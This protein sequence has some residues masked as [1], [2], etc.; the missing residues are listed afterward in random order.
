MKCKCGF[1]LDKFK[2]NLE[3]IQFVAKKEKTAIV[4]PKCNKPYGGENGK[5]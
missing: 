2:N 1:T 3:Y 4:C 5:N